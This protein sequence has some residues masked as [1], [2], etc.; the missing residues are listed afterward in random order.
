MLLGHF[1]TPVAIA[2]II[3]ILVRSSTLWL[4]IFVGMLCLFKLSISTG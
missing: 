2:S 1:D 4:A 3:A